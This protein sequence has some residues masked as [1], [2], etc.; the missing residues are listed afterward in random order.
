MCEI[1]VKQ[2]DITLVSEAFLY[3]NS[4]H[5]PDAGFSEEGKSFCLTIFFENCFES[6]HFIVC[7]HKSK[8][9][10]CEEAILH[11]TS[12]RNVCIYLSIPFFL[13]ASNEHLSW[14]I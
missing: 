12:F 7:V 3:L 6:C 1:S 9:Q 14:K 13:E 5:W 11:S 8:A 2:K 4:H 10:L